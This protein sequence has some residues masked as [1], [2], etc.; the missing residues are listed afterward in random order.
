VSEATAA[1]V[2]LQAGALSG[3]LGAS[4]QAAG[5]Q[6]AAKD[7]I[8]ES[9]AVFERLGEFNRAAAARVELAVCYWREGAYD[10]ARVV[11][12]EA[13]ARITDDDELKAKTILRLVIVESSAGR[14]SDALRLL[15]DSVSLFEGSPNDALKGRFHNELALV[16]RRLGTA[17]QRQDYFDRA[18]IE[19][20]A[21]AYHFGQARHERYVARIE[22]NLA[23]L[24]Y[25]L[26]R[27]AEAHEHLDYAQLIFTSLKDAGSLAQVDETRARVLIAEQKY[28]EAS[29]ILAGAIQTFEKGDASALLADALTV[30]GVMLAR[31]GDYDNSATT[32]RR[33]AD[34]AERLGAQKNAGLAVLTLIE[35]HGARRAM[36]SDEVYDA[37]LRADRLLKG[38][39]DV[40]DMAR[41]RAC[42]RVVM[43]RLAGSRLHDKDFHFYG[44]IHEL[45][46]KLIEQAL[47][48]AGGSIVRAARL[49]GITHQT[50]DSMLNQRHKNLA[51][52]AA[53]EHHQRA[54]RVKGQRSRA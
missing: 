42:S 18:I 40:E 41:L 17:E 52:E 47:E 46:A 31:L 14:Y 45:E 1:E 36:H 44:A 10:E 39:Q 8:S 25:K 43:R 54:G 38:T 6:E 24:L 48:E 33:A 12:E 5:A 34:M 50:L 11:L 28:R 26:G 20:T 27:Y 49:L 30:Q 51:G 7:L 9:A 22:N 15:T 37:Y 2:L 53:A 16:L 21:A 32:L 35:E 4:S 19:Y 13:A 3:W 23:F 29:R